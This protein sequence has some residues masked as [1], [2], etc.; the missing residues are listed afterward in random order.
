MSKSFVSA[1]HWLVMLT[2]VGCAAAAPRPAARKP[3][4]KSKTASETNTVEQLTAA[5]RDSVVVITHQGRD[6]REEGAGAGFVISADGLVATSFHVIGEARPIRVQFANGRRAEVTEVHASDRRFDLAILRVDAGRLPPL[7]LGNSESL[8]QGAQVIAI[9]NPLGLEGSVVQGV[10][11]ARREVEGIEMIQLA[12]PIEP[13]NSGGPLLDMKGRVQGI[14]TLKSALTPN[15]GFAMPVD[16]LQSLIDRPNPVPMARWLTLGAL[17]PREWTTLWG[18]RW[19]QKAGRI[20][21]EGAGAGFGGRSLCL[22]QQ[23]VPER[24][25]ELAVSVKLE[26]ESGAAGLVF[27]ADGAERHYGFYPS[28]GQLRLTRFDG[29]SVFSW[30][31]LKETPSPAYKR[32]EW[33]QLR[34]RVEDELI[35]CF[36]NGEFVCEVKPE[37]FVGSKAGLA[38]FRD[39]R[40]EFRNFL[41]GTNL[42]D[43]VPRATPLPEELVARLT[44][45]PYGGEADLAEA[46]RE[47]PRASQAWLTE[48]ARQLDRDASRLRELAAQVHRRSVQ[49][50]LVKALDGPERQIDLFHAALLVAKYDNAELDPEPYRAQ[51]KQMARELDA[52]LPKGSGSEAKLEALRKFLFT[53]HGFHGSRSDYYNRANSYLNQV[54]DDR[55]GLPITL[56]VLFMEL[57]REIGLER[58]TGLP[59]PGH[60]MVRYSPVDGPDLILDVFNGGR[61]VSRSEAQELVMTATG[62]G[63]REEH[64]KPASKRDI[65]ARMLRNLQGIAERNGSLTEV[66]RYLDLI[67]AVAPD[68][69]TDRLLRARLRI[70]T[71]DGTGAKEDLK[72]I[73]D[74]QP[75]GVNLERV[76]ELYQSL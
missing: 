3:E 23:P 67:V 61:T 1:S 40:A 24:P 53:E 32:G 49:T 75:D 45:L 7:K 27:G 13:G 35:Q 66:L 33:N 11:S 15:L 20:A 8:R 76:A 39:T 56:S 18:A 17:D 72:W 6:G 46:L 28:V 60:F 64:L 37:E 10:V 55:E 62:E 68:S 19:S 69:A 71:R 43:A 14:L 57:A 5:A 59:L 38:K 74:R 51:L 16:L 26:D 41:I 12:I 44:K 63:F 73:L 31:V 58:I 52:Q 22:S 50:E 65:I 25:F 48:R 34:V 36:V 47:H 70:Q 54:L 9:G 42:A 30:H 4:T 2:L 29:P 21:V